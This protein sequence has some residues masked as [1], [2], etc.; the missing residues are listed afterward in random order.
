MS[1]NH[2]IGNPQELAA[3]YAAGAMTAEE[4]VTFEAHL[5]SG[6]DDCATAV[7]SYDD[8]VVH[9]YESVVPVAPGAD[10]RERILGAAA[11]QA[12]SRKIV[13][14]SRAGKQ[15]QI[16]REWTPDVDDILIRNCAMNGWEDTGIPG[17]EVRRLSADRERN[18]MTALF[19]MA[20]G[21]AYPRHVHDGPEECYV[22]QG[23]LSVGDQVMHAGDYQKM[24]PGTQHGV[25]STE[26]GC[27][28]LIVSS[29][30]D[31]MN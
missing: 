13:E 19:R 4:A 15:G 22:L 3:A 23:D 17:I 9:L 1:S 11:P 27:V 18:Q 21:T 20:P 8:A 7:R 24:A 28:L 29:L 26:N 12:K 10:L 5:A 16:W 25:Q 2:Q 31:E 30:S 14:D 6:C